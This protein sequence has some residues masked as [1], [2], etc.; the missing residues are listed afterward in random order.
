[1]RLQGWTIEWSDLLQVYG[2][3]VNDLL[4]D[5][6]MLKLVEDE[7]GHVIPDGLSEVRCTAVRKV[8]EA[9]C[10]ICDAEQPSF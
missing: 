5:N 8:H 4:N 9:L 3:V 1:M 7:D 2:D 10:S 6:M